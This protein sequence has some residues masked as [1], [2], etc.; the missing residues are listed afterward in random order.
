M[1]CYFRDISAQVQAS[2]KIR[3]SEERY[4]ELARENQRLYEQEQKAR[5]AAESATRAKDEFLAVVSHELRASLN[6]ILGW[7]RMLRGK[8]GADPYIA[9][10]A[11]VVERSGQTQLQLIEDLLDTARIV[12]GKMHLE[13]G[14]V[15]LSQVVASAIETIRPVAGARASSSFRCSTR[16]PCRSQATPTGCTRLS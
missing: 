7:N 15:E 4:R 12:S 11:D 2:E 10:V 16:K 3:E 14:P 9:R 13:V 6:S 1:V 5:E 8:K